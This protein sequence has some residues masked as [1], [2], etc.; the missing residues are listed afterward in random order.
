VAAQCAVASLS[1]HSMP[2]SL[3]GLS[4]IHRKRGQII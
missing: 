1:H 3:L 4:T 2:L